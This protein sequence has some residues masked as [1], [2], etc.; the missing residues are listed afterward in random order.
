MRAALAKVFSAVQGVGGEQGAPHA[1]VL[2]QRLG[3]RDL[4]GRAADL[5][6]RQD[7]GGLAGRR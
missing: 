4:V 5:P 2:D 3:G 6:V 1:E 7:Q